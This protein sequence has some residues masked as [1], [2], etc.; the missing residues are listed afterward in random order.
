MGA[1][2][3]VELCTLLMTSLA[4]KAADKRKVLEKARL[5]VNVSQGATKVERQ[6]LFQ[7]MQ[8]AGAKKPAALR[9]PMAAALAWGWMWTSPGALW[10]WIS[11]A[12]PRKL[13]CSA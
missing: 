5:V 4:E 8:A 12:G 1:V 3:D 7:A 2:A 10:W 6:A 11:E 13:R 9:S